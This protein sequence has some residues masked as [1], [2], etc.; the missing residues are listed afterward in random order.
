MKANGVQVVDFPLDE[1][2]NFYGSHPNV[3]GIDAAAMMAAKG[4]ESACYEYQPDVVVIVSGFF[5]PPYM[6]GLIR[7]RGSKV[8]LVHTESP[9][10][11]DRQVLR[12]DHADLNVLNDPVNL[13]RFPKGTIYLPHCYDPTIHRPQRVKADQ[14]SDFCFVGT[15]YRSRVDFFEQVDWTGIDAAFAGNWQQ[16]TEDSPLRKFLAHDIEECCPNE[17]AVKLYCGTKVGANLYRKE[18][19]HGDADGWAMGPRE[20]ELAASGTF[21]LREPR[22]ESDDVLPM[23][24]TFTYPDE[25]EDKLRWWLAH[26][27]KRREAARQARAAI[28]DRTFDRNAATAIRLLGF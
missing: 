7:A 14:R 16:T 13:D 21:F 12:A 2:L 8:I 22:G 10:E 27:G 28:S 4:I 25:F 11:D 17:E 6:Y 24:P 26:P 19:D 20:V 15:G 23:L 9:Y 3:E 1:Q 5:V 18:A